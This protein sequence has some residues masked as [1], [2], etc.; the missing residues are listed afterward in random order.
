MIHIVYQ[1]TSSR[2]PFVRGLACET[3]RPSVAHQL[4]S[5]SAV[6]ES[7]TMEPAIPF[8]AHLE[9]VLL[10]CGNQNAGKTRLLRQMLGDWR[11]GGEGSTRGRIGSRMLSRERC[12]AMRVSSPHEAKESPSEFHAKIEKTL[13]RAR[14]DLFWRLNYASAVQPRA[15]NKMGGIV[16]V[17]KGLRDRFRPERIRVVHLAPDQWGTR[18]SQ[19]TDIEIDGLRQLDVEILAIDARRRERIA[20]EPGNIRIL[21]DFFDFS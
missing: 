6:K 3:F 17:C 5:Q 13:V 18:E 19:L 9:R 15:A 20:A 11:L 4:L 14:T 10:V 16:D 21:A 7:F 12:L 1:E 2:D 8:T